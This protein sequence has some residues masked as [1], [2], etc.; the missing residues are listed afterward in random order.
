[1]SQQPLSLTNA[2]GGT[3]GFSCLVT[4]SVP[5]NLQWIFNGSALA[6]ATNASLTLTNLQPGSI[7][8]YALT[9][10]N[11]FGGTVSSNAA[12]NLT[13]YP[14][15]IWNGLLA[16]YPF[17]GNAND[18]SGNGNNGMVSNALPVSDR[19]GNSA[20]AYFF[21]GSNSLISCNISNIPTVSAPRTISLW[22]ET[23]PQA[24]EQLLA[25]WG[26]AQ[27]NQGFG[28]LNTGSPADWWGTLG[29]GAYDLDSGLAVDTNWH[30]IVL[31]YDTTNL[32]ITVDGLLAASAAGSLNTAFSPLYIGTALPGGSGYFSGNVDDVRVYNL[33]LSSNAVAA[34]YVLES[35][36]PVI[37]MQPQPQTNNLGGMVNF[38]VAAT[39][40]HP[41]FYQWQLNG[42]FILGATN[43]L[44]TLTN[45][46]PASFGDY[47]VTVSNG[48]TGVLSSSATLSGLTP[49]LTLAAITGQSV[50][51]SV[52]GLPGTSYVLQSAT[53]LTPP[54]TWQSVLTNLTDTNGLLQI[55]DT[56]LN[57][58]Q[59]FY[60]V[61]T[62]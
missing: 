30:Q 32:S 27:P 29:G 35:D 56:N 40:V 22:G 4:G 13:G 5:I 9:A 58:P 60:R 14:F 41:L 36:L 3:A 55:S 50:S 44:L 25:G 54:V 21:N 16:Y 33:A 53:N 6:G 45:I 23:T 47:S 61:T 51:L 34:L 1:V 52:T 20:S 7:G 11:G 62:P 38:S 48:F 8:D 46:Q 19:F 10:T 43:A 31:V 37:T 39:A 2:V 17:N 28:I 12:L 42:A 24:S 49:A 18:A 59:K 57:Y 15:A 26:L